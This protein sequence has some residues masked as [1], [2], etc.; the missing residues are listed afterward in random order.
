MT[1]NTGKTHE[2]SPEEIN[3]K[4]VDVY[5]L[6]PRSAVH[7]KRRSPS[8]PAKQQQ[9]NQPTQDKKSVRRNVWML[10]ILLVLFV[11]LVLSIPVYYYWEDLKQPIIPEQDINHPMGE[12]IF[13]E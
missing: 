10:R 2:A 9:D 3:E 4:E 7:K 1:I 13:F 12:R 5:Q 11:L 6:P 8:K